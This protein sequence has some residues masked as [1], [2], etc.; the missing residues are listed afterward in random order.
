MN[1]CLEHEDLAHSITILQ[2]SFD[3]AME[4]LLQMNYSPSSPMKWN[5]GKRKKHELL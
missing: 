5:L 4:V 1:I 2:V 3:I